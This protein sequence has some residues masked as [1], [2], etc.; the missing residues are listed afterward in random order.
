MKLSEV[1]RKGA[2]TIAEAENIERARTGL[3]Q[4]TR[5]V[6]D[7]VM[8]FGP[9]QVKFFRIHCPMAFDNQGAYWL[10]KEKQVRNPYFGESMLICNDS[11]EEIKKD[12]K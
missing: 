12:R 5:P 1:I 6:Q 10:Q 7:A 3:K 4:I 8:I 2:K 11:I 9:P